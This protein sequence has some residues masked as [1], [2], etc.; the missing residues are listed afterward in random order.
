MLFNFF[1]PDCQKGIDLV[2]AV[3]GSDDVVDKEF[4]QEKS[5][6]M[7]VLNA[8]K[9]SKD[10]TH[11][12]VATFGSEVAQDIPLT[13]QFDKDSLFVAVNSLIRSEGSSNLKKV[14]EMARTKLFTGSRDNAA[15]VLVVLTSVKNKAMEAQLTE[16]SQA[17]KKSG[18][19]VVAVG[20]GSSDKSARDML[21][22]VATSSSR[23]FPI[24][25]FNELVNNVYLVA[26]SACQGE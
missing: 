6:I 16:F 23:V 24:T 21:N 1:L 25:S 19:D 14:L 7:N 12:A 9:I 15:K 26:T 4:M 5:F 3:D 22:K 2:F 8:F 10:Q 13:N 18:I 11:V 17:L 20:V